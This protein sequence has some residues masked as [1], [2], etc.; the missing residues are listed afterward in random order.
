[1]NRYVFFAMLLAGVLMRT[2]MLMDYAL[3][4]G[5]DV[6]V[7]LADEGVV[8]L[9]A[10]HIVEGRSLPVFFYGQDYLGALEA[11]CAAALFAVLGPGLETLR[12]VPYL[13]SLALLAVVYRFT[14]RAYSVAA[15]RWATSIVAVAPMYFLQWNLKA[16]GGFVEHVVLLFLVMIFFW[17]FY[18][19]HDRRLVTAAALGVSAGV[20][21]WVNQLALSY[22]LVFAALLVF[23]TQDRRKLGAAV[24]GLVVGSSL[25]IAYNVVHPLATVR[26]LARKAIVLNRVPVEER[27]EDWAL[28]GVGERVAAVSQGTG[29]LGLVFGVP[30][31]EALERLG[32]SEEARTGG[33]LTPLRRRLWP[34]PA[35]VFGLAW[36]SARPRRA[37]DGGLEPLGSSMVLGILMLVTILVGYVSPRYM[38][39]AYPLGAVMAAVLL[40][41]LPQPRRGMLATGVALVVAFNVAGWADAAATRG[42]GQ[43]RSGR[44]QHSGEQQRSGETDRSGGEALLEHLAATGITR[45][46]SAGPLYHLVFISEERVLFSP[47]QKNRYP[48]YDKEIERAERICY[49]FRD[50]QGRKRQHLALVDLLE[51]SGVTYQSTHVGGYNILSS[52]SPRAAITSDLIARA[53]D[54]RTEAP[55]GAAAEP[56][57]AE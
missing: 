57:E 40:T 28:R 12:L 36:L 9:M 38:L 24:A 54:P 35:V 2:A 29:K 23:A 16:R 47:L 33:P 51:K 4:D 15:A 53:R 44:Q 39:P 1:M 10:L 27:G 22:V 25:L 6:D 55:A 56:G 5:G 21:L 41:R 14:Y 11:Y 45:C 48:A 34:I 19:E 26:A 37:A 3:V 30:P 17:R 8:G 42:D 18:L 49:V 31:S 20:S 50:D 52:F 43:R 46:Y 13:F 7:Y 32:L